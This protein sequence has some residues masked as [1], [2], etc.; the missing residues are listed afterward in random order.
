MNYLSVRKVVLVL[1]LTHPATM[2]KKIK[3]R[4]AKRKEHIKTLTKEQRLGRGWRRFGRTIIITT[5]VLITL[6]IVLP[7]VI[8]YFV[9]KKMANMPEYVGHIDNM[10]I[11]LFTGWATI[12]DF[13]MKKKG[14]KVPVPFVH[15]T[16]CRVGIEWKSLFKGRIVASVFVN[17]FT[18]NFVKG[19]TKEQSQT[20]V[21]KDWIDLVDDLMPI[22]VNKVEVKD[23]QVHYR[24]FYSSP[25]V[26]VQMDKIYVLAENLSNVKDS[27]V[28]LPSKARVEA[29]IYGAKLVANAKLDALSKVPKF[30]ANV[31]MKRIPLPKLNEFT[32]A[33]GKFDIEKGYL[34]VYAEAASKDKQ[35]K[36]YVKPFIEDLNVFE[37]KTEKDEPLKDIA[38]QQ[39]IDFGSWF[40]ENHKEDNIA[41]RVDIEGQMDKPEISVWQII[42][43]TFSNAFVK[44][45]KQTID[46]SVNINTVGQ[47]RDKNWLEKIFTKKDKKE[48]DEKKEER[49]EKR[50]AKKEAREEKKKGK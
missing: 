16:R 28:I 25:K 17:N 50:E 41:T 23:G 13:D 40:I 27:S 8:L 33:Y 38:F 15:V 42:G 26:D 39:L 1:T 36:G 35:I 6:H 5:A 12:Y 45:F 11:N 49:K 24:D 18:V 19:P 7:V 31:E 14:G 10:G 47:E 32:K 46:N 21:D 22:S 34:S 30:D 43:E 20:K 44:A 3:D 37:W 4:R 29:N 9:N 2:L 48:K